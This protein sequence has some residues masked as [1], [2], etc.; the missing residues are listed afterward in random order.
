M[1]GEVVVNVLSSA[2]SSAAPGS[3]LEGRSAEMGTVL[4]VSIQAFFLSSPPDTA[5]AKQPQEDSKSGAEVSLVRP[6]SDKDVRAEEP[7]EELTKQR[8]AIGDRDFIAALELA[9]SHSHVGDVLQVRCTSKYAYGAT[10]R[11]SVVDGRGA[12]KDG[13]PPIAAIPPYANLEYLVTVTAFHELHTTGLAPEE[14]RDSQCVERNRVYQE[15]L[16]RKEVGNRWYHYGDFSSAAR[17]YAKGAEK[18]EAFFSEGGMENG[19]ATSASARSTE[20]GGLLREVHVSSW[21]NLAACHIGQGEFAKAKAACI[22]VRVAC[23][24]GMNGVCVCG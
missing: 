23:G 6:L 1:N 22:K 15:I 18:G 7:F 3:S 14:L 5:A 24:G 12:G 8:L 20:L 17:A 19:P 9:L 2:L 4:E 10:G 21:N 13:W 11:P 16:L